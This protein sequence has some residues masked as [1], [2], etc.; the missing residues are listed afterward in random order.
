MA[1]EY[2][3]QVYTTPQEVLRRAREQIARNHEQQQKALEGHAVPEAV[4][5]GC[6]T[7]LSHLGLL[8]LPSE[9]VDVIKDEVS[10]LALDH[11]R[12]PSLG[13]LSVR[14]HEC[15]RLRYLV[16]R[17]NKLREFPTAVRTCISSED[18][19]SPRLTVRRS[20]RCSLWS[21]LT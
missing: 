19:T 14:L 12:L 4:I 21:I 3:F 5:H 9:L 17:N 18:A 16:L 13:G 10:R 8:S 20:F 6:D 2:A 1:D 7:T 11:N 15:T